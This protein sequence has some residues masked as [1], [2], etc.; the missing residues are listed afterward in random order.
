MND[1][2]PLQT[3]R[4]LVR[5]VNHNDGLA[6][7]DIYGN[8]ENARYE[9]SPPWTADQVEELIQS[10]ADIRLGDPGVP[11]VLAAVELDSD[12]LVGA[13]QLTIQSVEELQGEIGFAFRP[14]SGGRGLATE[15]VHA[16]LGYGFDTMRMHRIFAGVDTRNDRSWKLLERIGMRREAHFVH[17]NREGDA[18]ID[19]Y[20]YAMLDSEWLPQ[21]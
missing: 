6:L 12:L 16:T 15:G 10:Q 7:L 5:R 4:L 21:A 3:R 13:I 20:I 8:E 1:G 9:F 17:A 11:F 14:D 2:L 19:E 18:W